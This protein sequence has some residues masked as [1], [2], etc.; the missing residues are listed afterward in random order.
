MTTAELPA[1]EV[2]PDETPGCPFCGA[3]TVAERPFCATCGQPGAPLAGDTLLHGSYRISGT[4]AVSSTGAVYEARDERR[5]RDV[6]VK[7]LLAPPGSS[8]EARTALAARFAQEAHQLAHLK[9]PCLPEILE[10]FTADG[11]FYVVMPLLPSQSLLTALNQ[12]GRGWPEADV[13][14]WGMHLLSLLEYLET[15]H[16]PMAHGEILPEHILLRPDGI[17]C[18]IGYGLAPR[19]GLRPYL[20]LPGQ[21]MEAADGQATDQRRKD[22]KDGITGPGPRDDLYALGAT[23]HALLTG[24]DVFAGVGME[25]PFPPVRA[26]A[27]R[28]SVGMAEAVAEAV[29]S[30]P[31]RRFASAGA[32]RAKLAPGSGPLPGAAAHAGDGRGLH[33]PIIAFVLLAVCI[34][35]GLV[36][37]AHQNASPTAPD[38]VAAGQHE[39]NAQVVGAPLPVAAHTRRFAD[40]FI[41]PNPVWPEAGRQAYRQHD[42][43]W[44]VNLQGTIPLKLTRAAYATGPDGFVLRATLR[45]A[46]GPLTAPYGLVAADQGTGSASN[47]A[48]LVQGRGQWALLRYQSGRATPLVDWQPSSAVRLGH[49]AP[50]E[51]VLALKPGAAGGSGRYT[52]TI[53]GRRVASD[54]D[55][56]AAAPT[57]RVGLIAWPG[58][59]VVCD[60][61]GVEATAPPVTVE[62]HFLDNHRGWS[63]AGKAALFHAG[64]LRLHVSPSGTWSE[65]TSAA[66]VPAPGAATFSIEATLHVSGVPPRPGEGGIVFAHP[67]PGVRGPTLAAVID[68]TGRASVVAFSRGRARTVLGPLPSSRIRTGYG[69]NLLRLL[70]SDR[71]GVLHAQLVVN[72]G[73]VFRYGAPARGLALT[74]G[75]VAIGPGATTDIS[76][77]RLEPS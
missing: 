39:V 29:A 27:P 13:R 74:T 52:V 51:L 59:Q 35:A 24:Y 31:R 48:L 60:A 67:A 55:A 5:K 37:Y 30:D 18:V 34:V 53:N 17:P 58:A 23:L 75:L 73:T 32:L 16:P 41:R 14:A 42:L 20:T 4:L 56:G 40:T 43:L 68:S 28:V 46:R 11:R 22:E 47:V 71:G 69:L 9:H 10:S 12:R 77:L 72:G 66:F 76:A 64:W 7:E 33:V 38:M 19:L 61:L 15:R 63:V 45:L 3:P 57:G 26:L 21:T 49:N 2:A 50:N 54:V 8:V 44:L 65:G 36:Y 1:V 6:A 62:E 70:V 25:H